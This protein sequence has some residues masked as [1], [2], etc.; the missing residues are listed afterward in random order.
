[1][2]YFI[3]KLGS[4]S[5]SIYVTCV[6]VCN[7]ICVCLVERRDEIVYMRGSNVNVHA[8][9]GSTVKYYSF[10]LVLAPEIALR[11]DSFIV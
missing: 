5:I 6:H 1:M 7:S 4:G 11:S 2:C 10:L 3:A 9:R 8:V